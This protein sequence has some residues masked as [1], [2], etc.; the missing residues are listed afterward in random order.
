MCV[1]SLSHVQLS[2][3]PWT[4]ARQALRPWDS[5]GKNTGGGCHFLLQGIFLTQE[6][7]LRLLVFTAEPAGKPL[8]HSVL[9]N[10]L[11][12]GRK[13]VFLAFKRLIVCQVIQVSP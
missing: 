7:N 10:Y 11:K 9:H 2:A 12:A 1:Q 5:L 6:S 3:I 4:V 13:K 8:H